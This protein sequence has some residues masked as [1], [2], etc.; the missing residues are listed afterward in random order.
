MDLVPE[1]QNLLENIL[2]NKLYYL[3]K[4]FPELNYVDFNKTHPV[5]STVKL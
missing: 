4:N 1:F 3:R 2:K 5:M